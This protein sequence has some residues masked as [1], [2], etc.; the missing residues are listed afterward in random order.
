MQRVQKLEPLLKDALPKLFLVQVSGAESGD[1]CEMG[2]DKL[3]QPL[4]QGSYDV[5]A[6]LQTL[7]ELGYAGPVGVIGFGI[8]QPA[9]THLKESISFWREMEGAWK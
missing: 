7:K 8:R 5:R 6:L 2:W 3:I 1:T 9:K 4:G